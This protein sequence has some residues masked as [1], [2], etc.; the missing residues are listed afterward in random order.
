MIKPTNARMGLRWLGLLLLL[1]YLAIVSCADTK[2]A[3]PQ[4]KMLG[5]VDVK[6]IYCNNGKRSVIFTVPV[7]FLVPVRVDGA[8]T[9]SKICWVGVFENLA[10]GEE[11]GPFI[12][13]QDWLFASSNDFLFSVDLEEGNYMV[14]IG[15]TNYVSD[16]YDISRAE[17]IQG[18]YRTAAG[19]PD[20][21]APP[22]IPIVKIE[23]DCMFGYDIRGP[24]DTL[25]NDNIYKY[26]RKRFDQ[27]MT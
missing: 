7:S 15:I 21:D 8:L 9:L 23:Y 10:M 27:G 17:Q 5:E 20:C 12:T 2:T 25:N 3:D 26:A 16:A 18:P 13:G 4:A 19:G 11:V 24:A 1:L 14:A 22:P 6:D